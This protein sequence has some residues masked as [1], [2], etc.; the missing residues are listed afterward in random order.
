MEEQH[1]RKWSTLI[2]TQSDIDG[3]GRDLLCQRD[4][5][6]KPMGDNINGKPRGLPFCDNDLRA[7]ETSTFRLSI[8][9]RRFVTRT[10]LPVLKPNEDGFE[11]SAGRDG[12]IVWKSADFL[13]TAG[14][15]AI[16]LG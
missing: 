9:Q 13:V 4:R 2:K 8:T 16:I 6:L 14:F 1:H 5:C 12:E 11:N 10:P 15:R 7:K 3:G